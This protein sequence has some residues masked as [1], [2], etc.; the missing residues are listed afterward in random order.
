MNPEDTIELCYFPI[1]GRAEVLRLVLADS[2]ARY[3]EAPLSDWS[4]LRTD[5][6]RFPFS[7]VPQLS[8]SG[9]RFVQSKAILRHLGRIFDLYGDSV[10][11]QTYIDM[12]ID[13]EE[14]WRQIYVRTIYGNYDALITPYLESQLPLWLDR[15]ERLLT[16]T[17]FH[18]KDLHQAEE[19]KP[20]FLGSRISIIDYL[21][22]DALDNNIRL[23]SDCLANYPRL[24]A[25]HEAVKARPRIAEYIAS[26]KRHPQVNANG[27][28]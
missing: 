17:D 1:R 13:G 21:I 16:S 8:I 10:R 26:P 22:F 14:D 11:Q 23:Q 5:I 7:Q 12:L 25:L 27:K 20:Y 4:T 18:S 24:A 3:T 28:G 9:D 6:Q 19:Q 15:F 2:D